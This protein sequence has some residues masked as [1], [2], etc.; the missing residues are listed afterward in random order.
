MH[1]WQVY[2]PPRRSDLTVDKLLARI[3][4][5]APSESP[6]EIGTVGRLDPERGRNTPRVDPIVVDRNRDAVLHPST[7]AIVTHPEV[8][9]RAGI[10]PGR[11]PADLGEPVVAAT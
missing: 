3:I 4:S 8:V 5:L 6:P 9:G 10:Q 1:L 11:H 7:R 2:E